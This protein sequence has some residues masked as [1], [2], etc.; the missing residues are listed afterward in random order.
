MES[1]NSAAYQDEPLSGNNALYKVHNCICQIATSTAECKK[2]YVKKLKEARSSAEHEFS[3]VAHIHCH[4][5]LRL[6][7]LKGTSGSERRVGKI[8]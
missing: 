3:N 4:L 1:Q 7:Q 5:L 8:E 6:I 2:N